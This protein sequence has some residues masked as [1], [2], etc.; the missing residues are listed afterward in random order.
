MAGAIDAGGL[1]DLLIRY[2]YQRYDTTVMMRVIAL[3]IVL[4]TSIQYIGD[5]GLNVNFL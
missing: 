1:G 2:G 4:V 3:L 5:R